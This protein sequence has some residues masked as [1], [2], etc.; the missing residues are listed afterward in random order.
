MYGKDEKHYSEFKHTSF[1]STD[2]EIEK[3]YNKLHARLVEL[4][5][6]KYL[7][8]YISVDEQARR[9]ISYVQTLVIYIDSVTY[10][11]G[12][13]EKMEL[14]RNRKD[15][16]YKR[17][18][19]R[20]SEDSYLDC[21]KVQALK[22]IIGDRDVT[23]TYNGVNFSNV[24]GLRLANKLNKALYFINFLELNRVR[25]YFSDEMTWLE[26]AFNNFRCSFSSVDTMTLMHNNSWIYE[27]EN[28]ANELKIQKRNIIES[29]LILK[30]LKTDQEDINIENEI[31]R[32][33][34]VEAYFLLEKPLKQLKLVEELNED[35]NLGTHSKIKMKVSNTKSIQ[36]GKPSYIRYVVGSIASL[37]NL[38]KLMNFSWMN[39][40]EVSMCFKDMTLNY[41]DGYLR[42]AK[43]FKR[44]NKIDI[45]LLSFD[46]WKMIDE[47]IS[48]IHS[49]NPRCYKTIKCRL[50]EQ[51]LSI[52]T[53]QKANE[54]INNTSLVWVQKK[55][56]YSKIAFDIFLSILKNKNVSIR[57]TKT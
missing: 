47:F 8:S 57:F 11:E 2:K 6:V 40:S 46:D 43:I 26:D 22:D 5:W 54:Y 49:Q 12:L 34:L 36:F 32:G 50:K 33:D 37:D 16:E 18:I 20:F 41:L 44:T 7:A 56:V 23:V 3:E 31:L 4:D 48:L 13:E 39:L 21:N 25:L 24:R 45:D 29:K 30:N 10:E 17:V 42:N 28:E 27:L 55:S 52:L 19:L 51:V 15:L 9:D 35:V 1:N 53:N 14:L 38:G